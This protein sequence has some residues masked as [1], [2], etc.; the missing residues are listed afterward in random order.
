MATGFLHLERLESKVRSETSRTYL[1]QAKR[2]EPG[3]E[4]QRKLL[5]DFKQG[6]YM[7]GFYFNKDHSAL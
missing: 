1:W 5:S 4:S 6:Y 7:S 3:P 2:M